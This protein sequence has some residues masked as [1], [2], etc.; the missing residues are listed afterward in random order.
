MKYVLQPQTCLP[1]CFGLEGFDDGPGHGSFRTGAG[2]WNVL[3]TAGFRASPG[4]LL[5]GVTVTVFL[6]SPRARRGVE[7][8]TG[9][10][11]LAPRVRPGVG[12]ATAAPLDW[13]TF[14]T[15]I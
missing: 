12:T 5:L 8:S 6:T 10:K 3:L 9:K 11:V 15:K 13:K 14:P 7:P 1:C 2:F 4:L